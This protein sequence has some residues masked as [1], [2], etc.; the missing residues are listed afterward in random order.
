MTRAAAGVDG[1]LVTDM[2]VE[3]AAS[4]WPRWSA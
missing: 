4:I 1:V 3:E 2:I